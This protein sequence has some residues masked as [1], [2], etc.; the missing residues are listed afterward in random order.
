MFFVGLY[1][2]EGLPDVGVFVGRV[3]QLN[4]HQ[5]QTV[6]EQDDVGSASVVRA[7]DGELFDCP[8]LIAAGI[9]PVDEAHEVAHG[10]TIFLVL[11]GDTAHQQL[12]KRAV[13]RQQGRDA[14]VQHAL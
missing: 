7:L 1:L 11:D 4:Q 3:L 2:V 14:E 6:D 9:F 13:G 10:F 5:R 8:K 12:V